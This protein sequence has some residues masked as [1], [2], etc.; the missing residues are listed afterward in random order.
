MTARL[1]LRRRKI[2]GRPVDLVLH[3]ELS[4]AGLL[5]IPEQRERQ[6][7]DRRQVLLQR[8]EEPLEFALLVEPERDPD[9]GMSP[10]EGPELLSERGE[11]HLSSSSPPLVETTLGIRRRPA[12]W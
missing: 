3:P 7:V 9:L 10:E 2:A 5:V 12:I 11:D 8:G 6:R 4:V 1:E